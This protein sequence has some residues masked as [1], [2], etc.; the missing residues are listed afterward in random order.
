MS[1]QLLDEALAL[2]PE[3][4]WL[5]IEDLQQSLEDDFYDPPVD[6]SNAMAAR[7]YAWRTGQVKGEHWASVRARLDH[8]F[9]S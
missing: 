4:R 1:A 7:A 3:D 2:A 5:L 6:E 8:E 9:R